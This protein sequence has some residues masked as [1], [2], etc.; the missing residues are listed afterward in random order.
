[1][2]LFELANKLSWLTGGADGLQGVEVAPLFGIWQFDLYGRTAYVYAGCVLFVAFLLVRRVVHSPFGLALRGIK[3]NRRRMSALGTGV[4]AHLLAAYTLGAA[5]AGLAGALL[6]QTTQF[7][8][9]DVLGFD[10]SA[11]VLLIVILGGAGT[12]YGPLVGAIAFMTM[13]KLLS[14]VTPQYWQF[15]LG[16]V[17]IVLVLFGKGGIVGWSTALARR[18][19]RLRTTRPPAAATAR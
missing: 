11:E 12:L 4:T 6:T 8:S 2:M 3:E 15:W 14:G 17:F 10:R 5:L 18:L 1:M 19:A 13:Q 9:L 7:V 16:I